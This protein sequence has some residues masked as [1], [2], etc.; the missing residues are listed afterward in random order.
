MIKIEDVWKIYTL[1]KVD[2]PVLRGL[3]LRIFRGDFVAIVGPSGSGKTTAMNM[4]GCLDLPTKG[5]I[6]LDSHNI[7]ELKEDELARIRGQKIGF[8]FQQFNLV[9]SLS[10]IEN[11][12]LPLFFQ[13]VE[14]KKS[15]SRAL[16]LIKSVGLEKRY[17]HKPRELSGG[18][19]QR[20]AI[21]RALVADPEIILADEPTGNLDSENG[22]KI[23]DLLVDLWKEH[24][25]TL[26]IVTHD[27]FV[28]SFAERVISLRDGKM[29]EN[30]EYIKRFLDKRMDRK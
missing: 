25:K 27:P 26:I 28:A 24:K 7:S 5:N 12:I 10:A 30:E 9:P 14:R 1:G 17:K 3:S 6:F 21:A 20:V 4:V 11:V 29:V 8:I 13:D 22:K 16:E 2:V 18:E 15:E 19:Q 23:M